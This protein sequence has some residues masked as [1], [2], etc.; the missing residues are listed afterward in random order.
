MR[1]DFFHKEFRTKEAGFPDKLRYASITRP[2]VV[3]GKAG[4]LISTFQYRGPD[5]Q[6]ASPSEL[7][8]MR[9][10]VAEMIQNL[11]AGWMLHSTTL[12]KQSQSYDTGGSFPDPVTAAI[13]QE[14][15]L[16]YQQ[17]GTHYENDYY[18]TFTYLP[19]PIMVSR[20]KAFAF[21]SSE[22]NRLDPKRISDKSIEYFERR[23]AEY[24][25]TLEVGM[26][27]KLIRLSARQ[28]LDPF[29]RE[30][31]WFDDQLS[32][33]HECIT[34]I[35]MPIRLPNKVVPM[36][37]DFLLGSYSFLPG[38]RPIFNGQNIRIVAIEGI[39]EKGTSVGMLEVLNKL[40]VQFR[41]TT[42]WIARDAEK[43]KADAK[44]V[45]SK[46]RQKIRGFIADA[47]GRV[48]GPVN[49]DAVK[50]SHDAEAVLNDWE[51]GAVAYGYWTSTVVLMHKDEAQLE[52][53][54]RFLMRNIKAQGF[55]C[56]DEDINCNE[57]F[58]GSLPGHGYENKRR[59]EIH[60]FNLA[61]CLPLTSTWQGPTEN[62]CQF[63]KKLYADGIAPP[64][65]QGAA[66]GGTPFRLVLHNGDIGHT[67]VA[68]PTG[69]GKSTILGLLAA[70]HFRYPGA[71]V[72]AFEKGE[73]MMALCLGSGGTH[74]NPM[75]EDSF[76]E[77][78]GFAPFAQI[79][80]LS[81][82][83]WAKEYIETIA[84]LHGI[85]ITLDMQA[86]ISRAVDLLASR[87]AHMR[88]ITEMIQM[89]Q[90]ASIKQVLSFYEHDM[91]GGMLNAKCDSISVSRFTVFEMDTLMGRDEKHVVPVLLYLFRVIERM[92]DGS[93][94]MIIL[95]EGWKL[96]KNEMFQEKL[97][98]WLLT[99]RKANGLVIFATQELQHVADTPIGNTIFSS[100]QTKILL[101][102]A[103]AMNPQEL[104]FYEAIGLTLREISLLA[105]ATQKRDYLLKS[106]AG[107]RFFQLELGPVA[108]AFIGA[109]GKED[110]KMVRQLYR[111]HGPNWTSHWLRLQG[112]DPAVLGEKVKWAMAA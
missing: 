32:F 65:L 13:E 88:S 97:Q 47:T 71:R 11:G 25:S 10:R 105:T 66:S 6:C 80:K 81:E 68:G 30:Q 12:R 17:E 84:A 34:G 35:S 87:P 54:V 23:M 4:E 50:M 45:R 31:V 104:P 70:S 83:V 43:A 74:Y 112:V 5:M 94:T 90:V 107:R 55:P 48:G 76:G 59:P 67:L 75:S 49:Q 39:P 57:A 96:L 40:G 89:V 69:S 18:L 63:Y 16:Q 20:V 102:H 77:E 26:N 7:N 52:S 79:D 1:V 92:L 61:D 62:P 64:L 98:E 46:W 8:Y 24:V 56:R 100:C 99:L 21:E 95:D 86:E 103:D 29:T 111:T 22:Q 53:S 58:L 41:W 9:I 37:V 60:S 85:T 2:G 27:T 109:T 110:R 3:L 73:S 14:R 15:I 19:D 108:L 78:I 91:A 72:F 106:Q 36:G 28:A 38:I 101:A 82:R 51:S 93:P 44:K 42:R 33:L